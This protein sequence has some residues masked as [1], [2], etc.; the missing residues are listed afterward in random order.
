MRHRIQ[1]ALL[2]LALIAPLSGVDAAAQVT[3]GRGE[4]TIPPEEP[5]PASSSTV[6]RT[7]QQEGKRG[8]IIRRVQSDEAD[9]SGSGRAIAI[10][11]PLRSE[12]DRSDERAED[13]TYYEEWTYRGTPGTRI[14]ISMGSSAFDTFLGWGRMFDGEFY[15][16]AADDDGGEEND[17]RLTV[18]IR[19]D[20][21]YVIR[22]NS[23]ERETGRYTLFVE[24]AAPRTDPG[25][26]R[27]DIAP[28]QSRQGSL[29]DGDALMPRGTYYE[30]WRYSG[31]AGQRIRVT[32]SSDDFDTRLAWARMDGAEAMAIAADDDGGEGSNSELTTEVD[33]DGEYAIIVGAVAPGQT[34]AYTLR[35]EPAS[36]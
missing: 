17:S 13:G 30:V 11:Q 1:S 7:P 18:W 24:E 9:F 23:F 26:P 19:D 3:R 20:Q 12:L 36:R 21:P 5:P 10:G 4:T 22:A 2:A 28:G 27:G 33:A 16:L 8:D 32:V 15:T 31:R 14:T 29:G 6:E 35:V 25:T 34:G